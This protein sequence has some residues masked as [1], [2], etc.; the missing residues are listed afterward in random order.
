MSTA[1]RLAPQSICLFCRLSSLLSKPDIT[2]AR[3][4]SRHRYLFTRI[5]SPSHSYKHPTRQFSTTRTRPDT[6]TTAAD[7]SSRKSNIAASSLPTVEA[8]RVKWQDTLPESLLSDADQRLWDTLYGPPKR[9]WSTEE[10]TQIEQMMNDGLLLEEAIMVIDE[11]NSPEGAEEGRY[12]VENGIITYHGPVDEEG[13]PLLRRSTEE[14]EETATTAAAASSE[15]R[16][17]GEV[18]GESSEGV[19]AE[20]EESGYERYPVDR[21]PEL[22]FSQKVLQAELAAKMAAEL[23]KSEAATGRGSLE[24]YEPQEEEEYIR[25]HPLTLRGRFATN[26]GTV[27]YP[28]HL[29]RTTAE[30]LKETKFEHLKERARA[31]NP[32]P[33]F[34]QRQ[35]KGDMGYHPNLNPEMHRGDKL[36]AAVWLAIVL[37][38]VYAVNLGVA[39]EIRRRLGGE[40]A[41]GVKKVLDVGGGGAGIIAWGDVV[42]AE[43]MARE[44]RRMKEGERKEVSGFEEDGEGMERSGG[45]GDT[46]DW[47]HGVEGVRASSIDEDYKFEATVVTAS[48]HVR[49]Y[50]SK[51]LQNTTFLPRTPYFQAPPGSVRWETAESGRPA[52]IENVDLNPNEAEVEAEETVS[53]AK[54][55][56]KQPPVAPKRS[57]DLIFASYTLEHIKKEN[58][59]K[60]HIDNL[61]QLLN[62]GGV[63]CLVELGNI[64]GFTNIA[65]ARHRLL[66]K[67]IKSPLSEKKKSQEDKVEEYTGDV[68]DVIEEDVLGLN[69]LQSRQAAEAAAEKE[70]QLEDGMIIA[71]CTNHQICPMY[72]NQKTIFKSADVCKVYQRYQ[73]SPIV[74][75]VMPGNRTN[76]TD[77]YFSYLAVQRGVAKDESVAVAQP[78][79]TK[80]RG[81]DVKVK[82][83]PLDLDKVD[84]EYNEEKKR[85]FMHMQPRV[86]LRPLKGDHHVTFDLCTSDGD[87]ERWIVPSSFSKKAYRDA[88]KARWGDLWVFGAK[89]KVLRVKK[90]AVQDR[91]RIT[92]EEKAVRK[93]ELKIRKNHV[94][95]AKEKG[96]VERNKGGKSKHV[97]YRKSLKN[98][99]F[100]PPKVRFFES[101]KGDF[102]G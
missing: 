88:R 41:L 52:D 55:D 22:P 47:G 59:F 82:L 4:V 66:R 61:W 73:Q 26:P 11:I 37:P 62:P 53:S 99:E 5:P 49:N 45:N 94:Q 14:T 91:E 34:S 84:R 13:R 78:M 70:S 83:I 7:G 15:G 8:A 102:A 77:S 30:L 6:N 21:D 54:E 24:E 2:H 29:Q 80:R 100:R 9:R 58:L 92:R 42:N 93:R 33:L 51:I 97:T 20:E 10:T 56:K 43:N 38:E 32:P 50:S 101:E 48:S 57:Y 19:A 95:G 18:T 64:V 44:E 28:Q 35:K 98:K 75:R 72:G 81:E 85:K 69:D 67:W 36:D 40:W 25:T 68:T 46:W 16:E 76:H 63:L 1:R 3:V 89:T 96:W 60:H 27:F 87:L 86:I 79:V 17:E 23:D 31:Y 90:S 39:T 12:T 65:N 74:Q 71:P